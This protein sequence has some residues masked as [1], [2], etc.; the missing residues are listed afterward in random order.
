MIDLKKIAEETVAVC[1][2]GK[3]KLP[4]GK[5]ISI[6]SQLEKAIAN[7]RLYKTAPEPKK[8]ATQ[9]PA[10]IRVINADT[11]SSAQA[12]ISL[13]KGRRSVACLNF[14]SATR[15]G[16]GFLDGAKAQEEALARVSGLYQCLLQCPEYYEEN[17]IFK[18]A[19]YTDHIIYSP[20]VPV[21]RD[22]YGY[23]LESPF[24]VS[25]ITAP[26]PNAGVIARNEQENISKI[27]SVLR[28]RMAKILS[29]AVAH[30]HRAIVLGAWGCGVFKNDPKIVAKFFKELLFGDFLGAFDVVVF[31]V[32]D[33]SKNKENLAAFQE[34]F[35]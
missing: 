5:L 27:D 19:L 26:A 2:V 22:S 1:K 14:A 29:I 23:F 7:T 24:E 12:L 20:D 9:K 28:S 4:D 33:P 21:F 11:L 8:F 16:G 35:K 13:L 17:K 25:F 34:A 32:Y 30:G 6:K 15:P 18:S 31:S 3:Y 10:E